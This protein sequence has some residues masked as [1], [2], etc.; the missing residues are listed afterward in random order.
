M[1]DRR[2]N[3]SSLAHSNTFGWALQ[4]PNGTTHRWN[5]LTQWLRSGS[6]VY[7]ICGKA[8]SGKSTLMRYLYD[9]PTTRALLSQWAGSEKLLVGSHFFWNLGQP[10]QKTQHGLQRSILYQI[11]H[12][13]SSAI[14]DVLPRLYADALSGQ[15]DTNSPSAAEIDFAY[16]ALQQVSGLGKICLLIDGMDEFDGR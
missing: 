4:P 15:H 11:L 10:E 16:R 1:D 7:W 8:G 12:H 3:V 2:L 14:R 5:D 9:H 13:K 6:G